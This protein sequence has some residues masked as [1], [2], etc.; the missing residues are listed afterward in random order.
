MT[1]G[2]TLREGLHVLVLG[3][4]GWAA[5]AILLSR[6]ATGAITDD[7][8]LLFLAVVLWVA[9]PVTI[10]AAGRLV[11]GRS[12][13]GHRDR[14]STS[15]VWAAIAIATC[16][17][18][19]DTT[20]PITEQWTTMQVWL[21]VSFLTP[22]GVVIAGVPHLIRP[23]GWSGIA[24]RTSWRSRVALVLGTLGAFVVM[25]LIG[26]WLIGQGHMTAYACDPTVPAELCQAIQP[27][28]PVIG[29]LGWAV[30]GGL[31]VLTLIAFALDLA[32]LASGLLAL[33]YL[34]F[35]FWLRFPWDAIISGRLESGSSTAIL[36]LHLAAAAALIASTALIQVFREP[37]GSENEIEL[38]EWLRSE[39]FLPERRV[40][41]RHAT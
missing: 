41:D 25:L 34:G 3:L 6:S 12:L 29:G 24:A 16:A 2:E 27:S 5:G 32:G 13:R 30:I 1:R 9:V 22:I 26:D 39:A 37:G 19:I 8:D 14:R 18:V 40:A 38:T 11:R 20:R 17:A 15:P 10:V 7:I 23:A 33:L 35:A 28:T 21:G 31:A 36:G 4:L